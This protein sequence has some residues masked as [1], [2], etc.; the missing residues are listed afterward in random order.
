[1]TSTKE[2][3]LKI[4]LVAF[5]VCMVVIAI[6][7]GVSYFTANRKVAW[8]L[9]VFITS[10]VLLVIGLILTVIYYMRKRHK[11]LYEK[12]GEGLL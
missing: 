6:S 8:H 5:D 1:M 4:F 9:P 7:Y 12:M 2:K 10:S 11:E 3:C